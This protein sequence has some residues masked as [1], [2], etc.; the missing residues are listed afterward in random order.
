MVAFKKMWE[1][2]C[3]MLEGNK[4]EALQIIENYNDGFVVKD[5]EKSYFVNKEDFVDLW[6]NML[7][8][9]KIEKDYFIKKGKSSFKYV[10]EIIKTLP[11][12]TEH[13]NSLNLTE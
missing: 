4:V 5:D 13:E 10:Y 9:N 2:V 8:F 3:L 11:Y 1:D 6:C 7:C 12:V